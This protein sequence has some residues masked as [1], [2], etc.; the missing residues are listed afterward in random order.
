MSDSLLSDRIEALSASPTLAMLA[1][2]QLLKKQGVDVISLSVG[3]PDFDTPDNIKQAA[4]RAIDANCTHYSQ[5]PGFAALREAIVA[6]LQRENSLIYSPEQIVTSNGGKQAIAQT[7]LA[8]INPGDEVIIPA[9]YWVSYPEM[10]RLAEGKAVI[11]PTD[12]Q[13]GFKITPDQLRAAITP[14]TRALI[15]CSP[16]NPTGAVYSR[17][18]LEALADVL[19]SYPRIFVLSDEIYEHINYVGAHCSIAQLPDMQERTAVLNG[20]SKGYAMTGW[21]L[22]WLAAPLWLAKA[23]NKL[24]GQ[25]T[26]GACSITQMAAIEAYNGP[27]DS[28][29]RMCEAFRRRRDLICA[30]VNDTPGLQADTPQGAFYIFP[31]CS[32]LFGRHTAD[33]CITNADDLAMYLLNEAHVASVAGTGFGAPGYIRFSYA[34]SEE[35][36]IEAFRRIRVALDKLN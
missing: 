1:R 33:T 15:L 30:L 24:Q 12:M 8:L 11:I 22:G 36:I 31:R 5:T 32:D 26:S 14:A 21:R 20:C 25:L 7:L 6:K 13:Q 19:R 34:N 4:K 16:S 27:Q 10:V 29:R 3:E 2:T 35:N 9:P 23:V 17:A 18:E 28:V